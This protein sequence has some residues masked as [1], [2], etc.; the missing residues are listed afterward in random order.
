MKKRVFKMISLLAAV[1]VSISLFG[2]SAYAYNGETAANYGRKYANGSNSA[3]K[4]LDS[5]CTNFVSQCVAVGGFPSTIHKNHGLKPEGLRNYVVDYNN[6]YWYHI[7]ETQKVLGVNRTVYVYS[8]P[9][10]FVS[11]F[12]DYMRAHGANV[13]NAPKHPD[14]FTRGTMRPGDVAQVDGVHSVLI[15][16]SGCS[17]CAHSSSKKDEPLST[18]INFANKHSQ[19][20]VRIAYRG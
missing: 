2:T 1:F 3:Y 16:T 4:K 5:D 13:S 14:S 10:A 17:Y 12:K 6:S 7:K 8:A 18:F 15:S 11:N 19:P 20:L 9:W